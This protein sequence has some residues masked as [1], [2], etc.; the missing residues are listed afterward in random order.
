MNQLGKHNPEY[1]AVLTEVVR[2]LFHQLHHPKL[3]MDAKQITD[4]FHHISEEQVRDVLSRLQSADRNA[5]GT[6]ESQP[7]H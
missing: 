4:W 5:G 1:M 3:T 7:N 6:V 2:C